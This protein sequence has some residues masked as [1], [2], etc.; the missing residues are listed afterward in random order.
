VTRTDTPAPTR[1]EHLLLGDWSPWVR[2]PLDVLR[3]LLVVAAVAFLAVEVSG[4]AVMLAVLAAVGW[5]VRPLLLPRL[6][7]LFLLLA[8]GL[9]GIGEAA[10][11]YDALPW[12]DRVVHFTFPLLASGVFY[13]ALARL[14]VLPDP[15]DDTRWQHHLGIGLVT[16]SL[17]TAFGA[18]WELVEWTSDTGFGS[19]LQESNGDTVGDLAM[20]ALGATCAGLLLVLWTVRGWGSVRRVPGTHREAHD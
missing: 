13:V 18:V 6:Y 12:F 20:D 1:L 3:I 19:Q 16:F 9:Q 2:D 15:R 10:G 11:A 8:L 4:G 14:D 5:A 17:G 7:D